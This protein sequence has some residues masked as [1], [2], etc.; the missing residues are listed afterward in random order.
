MDS[1]K[2]AFLNRVLAKR[3]DGTKASEIEAEEVEDDIKEGHDDHFYSQLSDAVT[4]ISP[5]ILDEIAEEELHESSSGTSND[6]EDFASPSMISS[7]QTLKDSISLVKNLPKDNLNFDFPKSRY[8][9]RKTP[10]PSR[11]LGPKEHSLLKDCPSKIFLNP[12]ITEVLCTTTAEALAM[13]KFVI[14]PVHPSNEFFYQFP[15]CL[16]YKNMDE[17]VEH[18]KHALSCEPEPLSKELKRIFTWEAAMERLVYSAVIS[19]E[20]KLHMDKMDRFKRDRRKAF[21]HKESGRLMKGDVL[22]SLVGNPPKESLADYEIDK[23]SHCGSKNETFLSFDSSS[24]K[25]ICAFSFILAIISY[26]LQS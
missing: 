21:L 16:A 14:L 25:V 17:F 4:S 6:Q 24:P 11:F 9:F 10:I 19:K 20:E 5:D 26:F 1:V 23:V 2:R 13:G 7:I 8:E 12:S 15:N 18:M 22:R 3:N